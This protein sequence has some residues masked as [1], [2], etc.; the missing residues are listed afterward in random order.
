MATKLSTMDNISIA[1]LEPRGSLIGNSETDE[2]K[3]KA[4][5]LLEQGNRKLIIDLS[6]VSYL[7]ST[8]IGALVHIHT[9]YLNKQG[10]V[11]LCQLGKSVEN[12]FVITRLMSMLDVEETRESAIKNFR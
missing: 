3:A 11:K 8:G 2:L 10:K 6:G 1:I 7:N 9:M 5:D 4:I 12:V